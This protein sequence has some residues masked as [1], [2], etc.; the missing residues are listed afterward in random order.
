[1][2]IGLLLFAHGARDPNWSLPF[3]A[4]LESVRIRA[5]GVPVALSYLEFMSPNLI[6]AAQA[7]AAAG[8]TQVDVV[9]LFLGTG[10]H[11]RKDLPLL[12]D[13]LRTIHPQTTWIVRAS[14]GEAPGVIE[15][16][17]DASLS[18]LSG[19]LPTYS[20]SVDPQ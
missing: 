16:I 10:G 11:V 1:M 6:D 17:A 20:G 8:C 3:Q 2:K 15:A 5:P 12:I 7:L 14:I 4:V 9:P 13:T 19:H 18:G